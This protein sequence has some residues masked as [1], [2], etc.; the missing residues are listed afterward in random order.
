MCTILKPPQGFEE[1]MQG[2]PAN[3]PIAMVPV[4]ADGNVVIED[5][6]PRNLPRTGIR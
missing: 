2:V 3:T 6:I 4:G 5:V 1:W